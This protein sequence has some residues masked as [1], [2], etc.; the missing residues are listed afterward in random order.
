MLKVN[1]RKEFDVAEVKEQ[2]G[3]DREKMEQY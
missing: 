3:I 2:M 1:H